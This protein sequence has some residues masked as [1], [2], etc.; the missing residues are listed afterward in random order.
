MLTATIQRLHQLVVSRLLFYE[1]N[2][3][4]IDVSNKIQAA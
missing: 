4:Q 1:A 3:K 2:I